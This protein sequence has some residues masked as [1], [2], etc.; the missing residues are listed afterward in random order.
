MASKIGANSTKVNIIIEQGATF[1]VTVTW[2]NPDGTPVDLTGYTGRM[3]IRNPDDDAVLVE[4]LGTNPPTLPHIVIVPAAGTI[5][6]IIPSDATELLDFSAGLYD[7][8]IY[9][10]ATPPY[11]VRVMHGVA[12]L[13]VETTR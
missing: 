8:E 7:L 5:Q 3:Q 1:D 6:M 12:V 13:D 10:A 2:Q 11:V 4:L 9:T